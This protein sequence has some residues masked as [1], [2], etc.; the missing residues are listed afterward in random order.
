MKRST[1]LSLILFAAFGAW[2][3]TTRIANCQPG[4]TGG[5]NVYTGT[6]AL[7]DAI[8]ASVTGDI[9]QVIPGTVNAGNVTIAGKGLTILGVGLDPDKDLGT[10]SLVGNISL[11]SGSSGTRI[12]GLHMGILFLGQAAGPYTISNI[13]LENSQTA[14]ITAFGNSNSVAN[15]V[16]RNCIFTSAPGFTSSPV[17]EFFVNSGILI[18]NNIVRDRNTAAGTIKGDG[19]T[20]N[21]N[22]FYGTGT[23][24]YVFTAFT[25]G[26]VQ[27]NIF[28]RVSGATGP[29]ASNTGNT[30]K[31]NLVF[32]SADNTFT[33]GTN[34]NSST[35]H[36][37]A[38]PL[39]VSPPANNAF[40]I[41]TNNITLQGT[42]PAINAGIDGTNIGP[43]G[44]IT[45][46]DAEGTLLPLI[47][48]IDMP[49][50]VTKGTDL[51]VNVKA[52]GN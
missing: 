41:Y 19:L 6:T 51:Q 12:S 9:I 8:N 20:V 5:V 40:W 29:I 27:N 18:S 48:S 35:D 4:A 36:I 23:S 37:I 11:N 33:N 3:Q 45:P 10:R 17:F 34:G 1:L 24:A 47:Q 43:T 49:S 46:F 42:S 52:K 28:L 31:N 26:L 50:V 14:A 22:L 32:G 7:Q 38:D 25:N 15:M 16:I 44:G 39:M 13:L 2:A 21:N 30:F